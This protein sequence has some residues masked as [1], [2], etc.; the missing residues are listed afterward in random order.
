MKSDSTSAANLVSRF[1]TKILCRWLL[2][3]EVS[4]TLSWSCM[5]LVNQ[6][7]VWTLSNASDSLQMPSKHSIWMIQR[8][9]RITS[10]KTKLENSVSSTN[11]SSKKLMSKFTDPTCSKLSSST[12]FNHTCQCIIR[13]F[14]SLEPKLRTW[15]SCFSRVANN[16][17]SFLMSWEILKFSTKIKLNTLRR[18]TKRSKLRFSRTRIKQPRV[19][20]VPL[21]TRK[22]WSLSRSRMLPITKWTSSYSANRLTNCVLQS[23]SSSNASLKNQNLKIWLPH[24][25]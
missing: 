25:C 7:M 16:P 23:V 20:P 15:H 9:W 8:T 22:H 11:H 12:I 17:P 3:I 4:G 13:M 5:T 14:W 1:H 24:E 2:A 19:Q 6:P 21:R 10:F 18:Q